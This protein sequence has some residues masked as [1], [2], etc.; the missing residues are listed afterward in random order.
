AIGGGFDIKFLHDF[1]GLAGSLSGMAEG[2][3]TCLNLGVA[4]EF[5]VIV[6]VGLHDFKLLLAFIAAFGVVFLIKWFEKKVS[7]GL[8]LLDV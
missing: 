1:G 8:D 4:T 6:G 7:E 2:I 5:A 3:L